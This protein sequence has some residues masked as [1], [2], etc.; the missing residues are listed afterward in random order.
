MTVT[1]PA[2]V[3]RQPAE[4][5]A[6]AP[7]RRP[8]PAVPTWLVRLMLAVAALLVAATGIVTAAEERRLGGRVALTLL[9]AGGVDGDTVWELT[10]A[11]PLSATAPAY[12]TSARGR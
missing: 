11:P 10:G 9:P 6:G 7:E 4:M 1:G 2:G 12:A 5:L 3:V 8:R